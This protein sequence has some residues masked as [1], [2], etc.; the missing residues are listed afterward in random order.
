MYRFIIQDEKKAIERSVTRALLALSGAAVAW[1]GGPPYSMFTILACF[2]LLTLSFFLH[3]LLIRFR[4]NKWIILLL[5]AGLLFLG[6]G[7]FFFAAVPIL[8]GF[9]PLLFSKREAVRVGKD[10]III[11]RLFQ[12]RHYAWQDLSNI[13]YKG[14]HSIKKL[15]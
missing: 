1:F 14:F 7:S 13:I 2:L 8:Y 3:S 9:L 12:N 6:T 15:P 10:E 4:L 11:S 5:A